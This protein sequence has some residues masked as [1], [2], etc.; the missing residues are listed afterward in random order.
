M[1][2]FDWLRK[3]AHAKHDAPAENPGLPSPDL[4]TPLSD[5]MARV[6]EDGSDEAWQAFR[7]AFMRSPGWVSSPA[8]FPRR[9]TMTRPARSPEQR[10]RAERTSPRGGRDSAGRPP[11]TAGS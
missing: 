6:L 10:R 7:D 11:P 9:V 8:A 2:L 1:G 5:L 3:P 4:P